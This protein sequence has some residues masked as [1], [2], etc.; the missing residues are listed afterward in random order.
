MAHLNHED[1]NRGETY[2]PII[3]KLDFP[4]LNVEVPRVAG[5]TQCSMQDRLL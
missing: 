2:I 3:G 4:G 5:M 1:L